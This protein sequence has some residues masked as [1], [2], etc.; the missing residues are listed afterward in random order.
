MVR[1]NNIDREKIMRSMNGIRTSFS[2]V[3]DYID[4]LELELNKV[5]RVDIKLLKKIEKNR[6][7]CKKCGTANLRAR[8]KT[9]TFFCRSCGYTQ[10]M[11]KK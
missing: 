5:L 3:I 11:R 1:I 8:F 10:T 4:T 2:K 6:P 7:R 9:N